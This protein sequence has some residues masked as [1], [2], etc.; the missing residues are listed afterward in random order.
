[1]VLP[2]WPDEGLGGQGIDI[3]S[4]SVEGSCPPDSAPVAPTLSTSPQTQTLPGVVWQAAVH[5]GFNTLMRIFLN[6][7]GPQFPQPYWE[8]L[9]DNLHKNKGDPVYLALKLL[10]LGTISRLSIHAAK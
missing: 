6:P 1:M 3:A 10:I 9:G 4:Q 2:E 5:D 7:S 8:G